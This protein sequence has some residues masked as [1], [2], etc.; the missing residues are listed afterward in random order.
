MAEADTDAKGNFMKIKRQQTA[1]IRE[2][3]D[4]AKSDSGMIVQMRYVGHRVLNDPKWDISMGLVIMC[5]AFSVAIAIDLGAKQRYDT[6]LRCYD[7]TTE[8]FCEPWMDYVEYIFLFAY[9]VELLLLHGQMLNEFR[10]CCRT[11]HGN[12]RSKLT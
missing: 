9:T 2:L 5:N 12:L 1:A 3:E 6:S 4:Q 11:C 10:S 7:P 8:I